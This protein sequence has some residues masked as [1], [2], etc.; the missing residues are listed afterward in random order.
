MHNKIVGPTPVK[1]GTDLHAAT[2]NC[3]IYNI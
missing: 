1:T 2:W 3:K